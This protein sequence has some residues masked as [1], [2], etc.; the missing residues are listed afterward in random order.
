MN[1]GHRLGGNRAVPVFLIALTLLSYARLYMLRDV[2]ADDNCW[3]LGIYL[4]YDLPQFLHSGFT[5]MR[6]EPLG[7]FLYYFFLPLRHVRDPYTVWHSVVLAVQLATPVVLYALVANACGDRWLAAL[8]AIAAVVVPLDF[9]IPY[10]SGFNYRVALFLCLLSLYLGDAAAARPR[11][12]WHWPAAMVTAALAQYVFHEA[13]M[14]IEPLRLLLLWSRFRRPDQPLAVTLRPVARF[15]LPFVLLSLPLVAYKL[16][17]KPFGMYAGMYAT[18]L[19]HFFNRDELRETYLVFALGEWRLLRHLSSYAAPVS[20]ALAVVAALAATAFI[21]ARHGESRSSTA[22]ARLY[23]WLGLMALTL[24]VPELFIF[25]LGG[26]PPKRGF[27]STHAAL[28]QPAYAMVLGGAAHALLRGATR[29]SR[30]WFYV[31]AALLALGCGVGTFFNNLN[32]DLYAQA[33]A[34]QEAFWKAFRARFPTLPERADFLI[35]ALPIPYNS[36][37]ASFHDWEDLRATYDLEF[38]MNRLYVGGRTISARRY[39]VYLPEEFAH[40]MREGG[41][42]EMRRGIT[43]DTHFGVETLYP[44]DMTIIVYRRG[45]LFVNR[46]IVE[47]EPQTPYRWLA[48]RPPP[49]W[50]RPR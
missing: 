22:G 10:L 35:D 6:R 49:P 41:P 16:F 50:A 47:R 48:D 37:I 7:V 5:E 19:S 25:F 34:R 26:R 12:G 24:L 31:A 3:L 38:E 8:V 44:T 23:G 40:D 9:T 4:G 11:W 1:T 18:G 13:S 17:V 32:L 45:E 2:Y 14:G 28:M 33:S 15:W 43:R 29:L 20:I 30:A 27:D 39:R 46:E 36:Q 42:T 21:P